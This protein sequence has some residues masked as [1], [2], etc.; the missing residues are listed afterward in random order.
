M[1]KIT[2]LSMSEIA[3]MRAIERTKEMETFTAIKEY[4]AGNESV[5]LSPAREA[6]RHRWHTVYL[7]KLDRKTDHEIVK[8]LMSMFKISQALAYKDIINA[9][10][11][12]GATHKA[13]KELNR[14]ISEQMALE[15]YQIAKEKRDPKGMDSA[16]KTYQKASG[17]D[18][19]LT[20]LPDFSK[21][22]P[23]IYIVML[24]PRTEKIIDKL[25]NSPSINL[26][27]LIDEV[28]EDNIEDIDYVET[29]T[30]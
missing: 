5:I 9:S 19:D 30:D 13:N 21:L 27:N 2:D 1:A 26:N 17:L 22:E 6:I 20:E 11:L 7:M 14:Q 15:T 16:N 18:D 12:F 23:N 24:D 4:Y 3:E 10:N 29:E 8:G 28:D 25:L